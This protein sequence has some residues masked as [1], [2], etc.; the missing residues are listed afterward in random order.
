MAEGII[1][2][3]QEVYKRSA[4]IA[5]DSR[6]LPVRKILPDVFLALL[7]SVCLCLVV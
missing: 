5:V 7:A 3:D 2:N 4:K 6:K 1:K